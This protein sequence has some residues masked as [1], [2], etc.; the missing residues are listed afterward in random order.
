[1]ASNENIPEIS[2][3]AAE[4]RGRLKSAYQNRGVNAPRKVELL[5]IFSDGTR[6]LV[7]DGVRN[8]AFYLV[9]DLTAP[10]RRVGSASVTIPLN[11]QGANSVVT[12]APLKDSV[13]TN[14]KLF[15]SVNDTN[16]GN[17]WSA[18]GRILTTTTVRVN[19]F[20]MVNS[21]TSSTT[22]IVVSGNDLTDAVGMATSPVSETVTDPHGSDLGFFPHGHTTVGHPISDSGHVHTIAFAGA[23][24]TLNVD[25]L[26][27]HV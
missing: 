24:L 2:L 13:L 15:A 10:E 8:L 23:A 27:W 21:V 3:L 9:T 18:S 5:G 12:I 7:E 17:G 6:Y 1:M 25:W 19:V 4:F 20:R 22:G 11:T 14:Y 16:S 26:I